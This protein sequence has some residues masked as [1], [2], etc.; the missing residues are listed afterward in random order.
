MKNCWRVY[1]NPFDDFG[2][3][4]GYIE[5]TKDVIMSSLGSISSALDNTA[6][7]IGVFRVSNFKISLNNSNGVYSDV[8]NEE[9]IFRYK[10]SESLIK[11]TWEIEDFGG[12]FVGIAESEGGYLSEETTMFIGLLNDD[13]LVMDLSKQTVDFTCLGRESIF[14]KT[15]LP[16]GSISNG[17][18]YSEVLYALLNLP[19]ITDLLTVDALNISCGCDQT[20]D[21][22]AGFQNKTVTEGLN[23]ML[24][25]SNSVLYIK[26]D[27]VYVSPRD[28]GA[29]VAFTFHG[30]GSNT[31]AENVYNIS[32]IKNGLGKTFNFFTWKATALYSTDI[33]STLKYGSITKELDYE[34]CTD[35]TKRQSILDSLRD[36]FYAPKQEFDISTPLTYESLLVNLL[37][38]VS[39]NYPRV[40]VSVSGSGLPI[41]GIAVCGSSVLP[42][43]LWDFAVADTDYY[44]VTGI[45]LNILNSI[46]TFSV[47]LI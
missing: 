27:T 41:C 32:N 13:S 3:Y 45:S 8:G 21:S 23:L 39:I 1:I 10:R 31:G 15:I 2:E 18:L 29:T 22:I 20:I 46:L 25:A 37:D 26:N 36:E 30:Q 7:D 19:A 47:R 9:S 11:I 38:K 4:R 40:Y 5:V 35:T 24:L 34:F 43:A 16:F 12:P 44:K 33:T 6:Y 28:A 42:K 14:S 17:D